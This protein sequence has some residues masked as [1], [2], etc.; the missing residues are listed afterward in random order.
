MV[1]SSRARHPSAFGIRASRSL[2]VDPRVAMAFSA[3]PPSG[4]R[5]RKEQ[6]Q[7]ELTAANLAQQ[8]SQPFQARMP[9][10]NAKDGERQ[11][12]PLGRDGAVCALCGNPGHDAEVCADRPAPRL[13]VSVDADDAL[14]EEPSMSEL[15][16]SPSA[17]F[18]KPSAA[19]ALARRTAAEAEDA[20]RKAKEHEK[21]EAELRALDQLHRDVTDGGG[22][23]ARN[24]HDPYPLKPRRT[25]EPPP[26]REE[27]LA[28]RAVEEAAAEAAKAPKHKPLPRPD[29]SWEGSDVTRGLAA[30]ESAMAREKDPEPSAVG[31]TRDSRDPDATPA[32]EA[33][34]AALR[35]ADAAVAAA[36]VRGVPN[37]STDRYAAVVT[38]SDALGTPN[39]DP[40]S[41]SASSLSARTHLPPLPT[42]APAS[43]PLAT[44]RESDEPERTDAEKKALAGEILGERAARHPAPGGPSRGRGFGG[45]KDPARQPPVGFDAPVADEATFVTN[46]VTDAVNNIVMTSIQPDAKLYEPEGGFRAVRLALDESRAEAA[47]LRDE[48][49]EAR[50]AAA[51]AA[52]ERR[53]ERERHAVE[54]A[55]SNDA[56]RRAMDQAA[57]AKTERAETSAKM[58]A[59][60]VEC[61]ARLLAAR[62]DAEATRDAARLA[63][64]AVL[65]ENA[66]LR[67]KL[68][69]VETARRSD[70]S[71][72]R[73]LVASLRRQ[74]DESE[75]RRRVASETAED[76][77]VAAEAELAAVRAQIRRHAEA[78]K[79]AERRAEE[80][81]KRATA[82]EA[83]A[84]E[85]ETSERRLIAM[86]RRA[87]R[88]AGVREEEE[89]RATESF[90]ALAA[91]AAASEARRVRAIANTSRAIANTSRATRQERTSPASS[92]G[93]RVG[94]RASA[95]STATDPALAAARREA[96][97]AAA[98]DVERERAAAAK[99]ASDA[100]R[101]RRKVAEA[102]ASS[103]ASAA[104]AAPPHLRAF[105]L[106]SRAFVCASE[107]E[108]FVAEEVRAALDA[109]GYLAVTR[110]E[111]VDAAPSRAKHAGALV[112]LASDAARD[113]PG[114]E[115]EIS[116]ARDAGRVVVA[117]VDESRGDASPLDDG[118]TLAASLASASATVATHRTGN[119]ASAVDALARLLGAPDAF[120]AALPSSA[121]AAMASEARDEGGAPDF[122]GLAGVVAIRAAPSNTAAFVDALAD[123]MRRSTCTIETIRLP[124]CD[125]ASARKIAAAATSSRSAERLSFGGLILPVGAARR[126]A[127][128]P[129]GLLTLDL[130]EFESV[131][132]GALGVGEAEEA[133]LRATL[134]EAAK[135]TNSSPL[136]GST[137]TS[138][139]LPPW[140]P[141]ATTSRVLDAVGCAS[142][143]T[144]NDVPA[145]L[146]PNTT[147][148]DLAGV[149]CGAPGA[150]ALA[151]AIRADT[152]IRLA[153]LAMGGT[154]LGAEGSAALAEVLA[155]DACRT[156]LERLYLP[157]AA[158]GS[159]GVETVC[160]SAPAS[161]V[162]LDVGSNDAGDRG[163]DAVARATRRC[164]RL[165]RLGVA[166]N[167]IGPEGARAI[168]PALRDHRALRELHATGNRIG[169]RG[170]A[171]MCA[172]IR[173]TAAPFA[174]L[175]LD[176][177]H[178]LTAAAA[179]S[180]AGA[181]A[182]STTLADLNL[183]KAMIGAEG[184]RALV[185][186][187]VASTALVALELGGCKLRAEGAGF[188]G[189]ALAKCATLRRL[190]VSRNSLGDKGVFELVAR[191]L[192][193]CKS[194]VELDL[195]HNAVGPEGAK[196]LARAL[197][198]KNV[199]IRVLRMEGNKIEPDEEAALVALASRE[200]AAPATIVKMRAANEAS[201]MEKTP[202]TEK[203]RV[204]FEPA[205][206]NA[207]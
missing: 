176:E 53:A 104:S 147:E 188:L 171:A 64:N 67:E 91:S 203:K 99:A 66:T 82:A 181:F 78:T 79:E 24:R 206:Q 41:S 16:D 50:A 125:V 97:A 123:V 126:G 65:E 77:R 94:A 144:L 98:A 195:R 18:P 37:V 134:E 170:A 184:A 83:R 73:Q 63:S 106:A 169:D 46:M 45:K 160:A 26:T 58:D 3:A 27:E 7:R 76:A 75:S 92:G 1:A 111:G 177:N 12:L 107:E 191:G 163:A 21:R 74:V 187:V 102:E 56:A 185:A 23:V 130:T 193:T 11:G 120:F 124:R 5:R 59:I 54:L 103:A 6:P 35:E 96:L 55:E 88:A 69:A 196:R 52:A 110:P 121:L 95:E 129:E 90:G 138:I 114:V 194:L 28:A 71:K 85:A 116:A 32:P 100:K 146:P 141:A 197:E 189:D 87:E 157:G 9:S 201:K 62:E 51:S 17:L 44:V 84:T 168:A 143:P 164:E 135:E 70:A 174:T 132:D 136:A 113:D 25:F 29:E 165:E 60:R 207:A 68:E 199:K 200:R 30:W 117:L 155:S 34:A 31:E 166:A 72:S 148:V 149:A 183:A 159:L 140:L 40:T 109:A 118:S 133:A 15:P 205:S 137:V 172:A 48:L 178:N 152:S 180:L 86:R 158:L 198:R 43:R 112:V 192:E 115:A 153:T 122:A 142:F 61:D 42:P 13:R 175:A 89:A 162:A 33:V 39:P 22:P 204:A 150:M 154:A 14:V 81:E 190:G 4:G 2:T 182:A 10:A 156:T 101:A 20:A 161:L 127:R 202:K 57:R 139:R 131:A 173:A 8:R 186:G 105:H 119:P 49:A 179:K 38:S 19:E 36:T 128:K 167:D 93:R 80:A 47:S 145:T 151:A 108:A